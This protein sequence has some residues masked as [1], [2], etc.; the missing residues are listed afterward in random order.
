MVNIPGPILFPASRALASAQKAVELKPTDWMCW[1]TLGVVAFRSRDWKAAAEFL[2]K[3]VS[4]NDGGGA[5]DWFFLA[6]IRWH[7]GKPVVAQQL[8]HQAADYL[9]HNPGDPELSKFHNEAKKLLAQPCPNADAQ[10]YTGGEDEDL[11]ETE[12]RG[13]PSTQVDSGPICL[14]TLPRSVDEPKHSG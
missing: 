5:I 11:T 4:L 14:R 8:F 2:E 10:K 6:M 13:S 7:Q 1:N 3:S 12:R 9:K